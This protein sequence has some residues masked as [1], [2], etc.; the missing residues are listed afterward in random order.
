MSRHTRP[1]GFALML[2]LVLLAS[3][4]SAWAVASRQ[5]ASSFAID[6][7][8]STRAARDEGAVYALGRGIALLET[9]NPPGATDIDPYLCSLLVE[10]SAGQRVFVVSFLR[11]GEENE[12]RWQVNA[13]PMS[14]NNTPDPMPTSF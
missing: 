1:R 11:L 4:G 8:R 3:L 10:T 14:G 9:G 13:S 12:H 7:A 2:V 6:R 5:A